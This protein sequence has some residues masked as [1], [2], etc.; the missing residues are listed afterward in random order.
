MWLW[1]ELKDS[2]TDT[3][4]LGKNTLIAYFMMDEYD[5]SVYLLSNEG[6]NGLFFCLTDADG[7]QDLTSCFL[8]FTSPRLV[9]Q[10]AWILVLLRVEGNC[11][12]LLLYIR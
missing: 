2:N 10:L 1:A 5:K 12:R 7:I 9:L 4:H 11:Q 6:E 3:I 8:H